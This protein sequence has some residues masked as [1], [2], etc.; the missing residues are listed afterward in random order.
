MSKRKEKEPPFAVVVH[1]HGRWIL[2]VGGLVLAMEGDPC[3]DAS[4]VETQWTKQ[5]L[6]EAATHITIAWRDDCE[7]AVIN[8]RLA[9][10]DY[11]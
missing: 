6:D 4:F 3:R 2:R 5:S 10:G 11:Q 9:T 8:H 7:L 1:S